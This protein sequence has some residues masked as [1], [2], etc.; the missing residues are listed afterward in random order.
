LNFIGMT[1]KGADEKIRRNQ[2]L[3]MGPW[4]HAINSTAKLGEVDFGSTA[5][6][7]MNAYWLRWFD[8]WLKGIDNGVMNEP[9]VR[10]FVMGQNAWRDENEWPLARTSWTKYYLHSNGHANTLS[11][12]GT[13]SS[14]EPATEPTDN[15]TYDPANPVTFITDASFAQIGGPDDYREIEK[16]SDVL[17]YTSE[18]LTEDI[19]VCGPVKVRLSA[20]SSAQDTD[21]MAKLIDVWPNG[22]A[23]RLTDGMVR[24]RF[25]AGMDKPSLIEPERIY[26]YD[27]DL[28]NT[29]QLYKKGHRIRVEI[30]SSAF[31]KYDRN[32]NTGEPLGQTTRMR[33]AEQKIYHDSGR[34]SYIILPIVS[35]K[36]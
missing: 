32:L 31:P 13:L 14:A 21:F 12:D 26:D 22:F 15:Y 36:P 3:M 6:I 33:T 8:Y 7:D 10:I 24:A 23:Q 27:L 11:G 19:E 20:A 30:S 16:R 29:C 4:P 18:L 28:W 17:V 9:P 35:P 25:R 1:T 34:P 5:V 2:K